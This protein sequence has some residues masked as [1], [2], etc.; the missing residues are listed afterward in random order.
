MNDGGD[1]DR[2]T[3]LNVRGS[4]EHPHAGVAFESMV[5]ILGIYYRSLAARNV[6]ILPYGDDNDPKQ[7]PDTHTTIR[8]PSRITEFPTSKSNYAWYKAALTHRAAHYERGTFEFLFSRPAQYFSRIRPKEFS[9]IDRYK[10]ESDLETFFKLFSQKQT[11]L[12]VFTVLEALRLDEWIKVRY[13]GFKQDFIQ[14][15]EAALGKRPTFEQLCPRDAFA[16]VMVRLS[17]KTTK[18]FQVPALLHEPIRQLKTVVSYLE[19]E[20][21]RVEDSAEATLRI[22]SLL[23]KLPNL[24]ANYGPSTAVDM[25]RSPHLANWANTW[26]EVEN[27]L[28]GDEVLEVTINPVDY[29]DSLGSRYTLYKAAGPIDQEVIFRF[30]DDEELEAPPSDLDVEISPLDDEDKNSLQ[31]PIE[32]LPHEHPEI[33]DED[34]EH[35]TGELHSHELSWFIYPEWD[36]IAN[37][38]RNNW[39]CVR[40]TPIDPVHI[41]RFYFETLEAY[42]G[43]L[44][45]IQRLLERVAYEGLHEVKRSRQGDLLDIDAAIE[46]MVDL[47]MG[48]TPSE[49]IYI[50][51][52]PQIRDIATAFVVDVS[53]STADHIAAADSSDAPDDLL[54]TANQGQIHGKSYRT[55]LDVE[56]ES[57]ALIMAALERIGDTYGVYCFS[58]TGRDDVKCMVLKELQERLSDQVVGRL[59][60]IQ[61]VHTTRMA[62]LIRHISAKLQKYE[63]KTK[64]LILISDGRPFDIDYG[65]EYGEDAEIEYA[66][67]DTRKALIE[68]RD[69]GTRPFLLTVDR[70]GSDYLRMMCDGFDYEVLHDTSMLPVRLISLYEQATL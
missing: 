2:T 70:D 9:R 50:D 52:K 60:A 21:A 5:P 34:L 1:Q 29:R 31:G 33:S 66:L 32:P 49:H 61:P 35:Q 54:I 51:K 47:R 37:N 10:H 7:Y 22:Y 38:Y 45:D 58:G 64:L 68:A 40:E 46:A 28:E 41:P 11:A 15:Q 8:L 69:A 44:P 65:Q 36:Y 63:A 6:A 19:H 17:L 57:V 27:R 23:V 42:A 13:P 3:F 62:P 53:S 48:M 18:K 24:E 14:I 30:T 25:D 4:N 20:N 12:E 59:D 26:P 55:I 67:Q 43:L 16:E 39:C 56:K